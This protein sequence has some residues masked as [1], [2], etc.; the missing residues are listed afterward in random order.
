MDHQSQYMGHHSISSTWLKKRTFYSTWESWIFNS[1][2]MITLNFDSR[3]RRTTTTATNK[4]YYYTPPH[5]FIHPFIHS[6]VHSSQHTRSS[7]AHIGAGF[8]LATHSSHVCFLKTLLQE[9]CLNTCSC[10]FRLTMGWMSGWAQKQLQARGDLPHH[11][12]SLEGTDKLKGFI[13][14]SIPPCFTGREVVVFCHP[15]WW[16]LCSMMDTS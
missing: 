14:P 15:L 11:M 4:N 7:K 6:S 13:S 12:G 10:A 3:G 2:L 16:I 1:N 5:P 9:G 8:Q